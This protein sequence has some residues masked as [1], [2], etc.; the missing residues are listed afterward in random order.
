MHRREH[1]PIFV[2]MPPSAHSV[3]RR[4]CLARAH[5]SSGEIGRAAGVAASTLQR[6]VEVRHGPALRAETL[7]KLASWLD[8]TFL[9]DDPP[10]ARDRQSSSARSRA[11]GPPGGSAKELPAGCTEDEARD[12]ADEYA[13]LAA[14]TAALWHLAQA[15]SALRQVID[16]RA[17]RHLGA[18]V[19]VA[20][21]YLPLAA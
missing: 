6:L 9:E 4:L 12:A 20:A 13:A 14:T 1:P 19:A 3:H 17:F 16:S 18:V 10:T 15:R 5:Y 2:R 7:R 8:A 21:P 11:A